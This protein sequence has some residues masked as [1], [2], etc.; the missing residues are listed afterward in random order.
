MYRD[1]KQ[2]PQDSVFASTRDITQDI[3][4]FYKPFFDTEE[5]PLEDKGSILIHEIAHLVGL[6][7]D[8]ET[9]AI[10]SAE[11]LR[12]F[13]LLCTGKV[14][15]DELF[16]TEDEAKALK[17]SDNAAK[18][19]ATRLGEHLY[20]PDQPRVEKGNPNGGQWTSD[21]T[22]GGS[23]TDDDEK[24][25]GNTED[26][27]ADEDEENSESNGTNETDDA[28]DKNK[29]EDNDDKAHEEKYSPIID[30]FDTYMVFKTSVDE[31]GVASVDRVPYCLSPL[32]PKFKENGTSIDATIY[33]VTIREVPN[34]NLEN[35][36]YV[37]TKALIPDG[38]NQVEFED[39]FN[40]DPKKYSENYDG[41]RKQSGKEGLV[42]DAEN[43][44]ESIIENSKILYKGR[45]LIDNWAGEVYF[46]D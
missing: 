10:N 37:D 28:V 19:I 31:N 5:T 1:K 8:R 38:K 12:N 22:N 17:E 2:D 35:V 21:G 34:D 14:T 16:L 45:I 4:T 9:K 42:K 24:D 40:K 6:T 7:S 39:E 33:E 11:A 32:N 36:E 43:K 25:S 46:L 13:L 41:C 26:S 44:K 29:E 20:N 23:P 18:K 15:E 27:D 3:I 30:S